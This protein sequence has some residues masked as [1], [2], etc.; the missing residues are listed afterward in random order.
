MAGKQCISISWRRLA[1]QFQVSHLILSLFTVHINYIDN[2]T[3]SLVRLGWTKSQHSCSEWMHPQPDNKQDI[4]YKRREIVTCN[5]FC[6]NPSHY[7]LAEAYYQLTELAE[8]KWCLTAF[9]SI[10][11]TIIAKYK[12]NKEYFWEH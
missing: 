9:L 3:S 11:C 12:S 4:S 8:H 2:I 10:M 1:P 5:K 7:I 6:T